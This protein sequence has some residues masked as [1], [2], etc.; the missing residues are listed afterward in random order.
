MP[1]AH[2]VP[3]LGPYFKTM[4]INR[5]KIITIARV[6]RESSEAKRSRPTNGTFKNHSLRRA[7]IGFTR[8]ARQAGTRQATSATT[9]RSNTIAA[10][11]RGSCALV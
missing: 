2:P 11:V 9:P 6:T 3:L 7:I 1:F 10:K 5:L 4:Q 8:V